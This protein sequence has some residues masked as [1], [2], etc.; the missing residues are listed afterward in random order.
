MTL[1]DRRCSVCNCTDGENVDAHAGCRD[2]F[3]QGGCSVCVSVSPG[4]GQCRHCRVF[5]C[6]DHYQIHDCASL[7]G[8]NADGCRRE[9]T[10]H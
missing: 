7:V 2:A 6:A 9:G 10:W 8:E 1:G 4:L 5:L 3:E